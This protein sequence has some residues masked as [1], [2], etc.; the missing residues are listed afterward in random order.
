MLQKET[1]EEGTLKLLKRLM[2]DEKLSSFN[3]LAVQR[4]RSDWA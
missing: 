2:E 1:V 3:S 4:L